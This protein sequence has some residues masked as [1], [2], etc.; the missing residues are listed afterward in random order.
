M[1][2]GAIPP[3]KYDNA[4]AYVMGENSRKETKIWLSSQLKA[5]DRVLELG[6][7]TGYFSFVVG[8]KAAHLTATDG[9][10]KM[11]FLA[12]RNLAPLKNTTVRMENC[13]HTSFSDNLFDAVFLGNVIHI[14][15]RPM[16]VLNECHRCT[17]GRRKHRAGGFHFLRHALLFKGGHDHSLSEEI[18]N[19]A[20]RE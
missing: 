1:N 11:L 16:D 20:E 12:G 18:W 8:E 9:S 3:P 4:S 5:T 13:Y 10:S 7:G 15:N 17:E 2:T 19:P 14:V 6:C